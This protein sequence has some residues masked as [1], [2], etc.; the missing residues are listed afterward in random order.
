MLALHVWSYVMFISTLY[1]YEGYWQYYATFSPNLF[2]FPG[3]TL[4][5]DTVFYRFLFSGCML[6]KNT[7]E[8]VGP[9]CQYEFNEWYYNYDTNKCESFVFSGCGGNANRFHDKLLCDDLCKRQ[10][11]SSYNGNSMYFWLSWSNH[12]ENFR[13]MFHLS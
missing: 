1:Y 13:D 8:T 10:Y 4:R 2:S 3:Y 11:D 6:P 9:S 7:G 12:F 5:N